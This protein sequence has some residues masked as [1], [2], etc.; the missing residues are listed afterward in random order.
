MSGFNIGE[1]LSKAKDKAKKKIVSKIKKSITPNKKG[2]NASPVKVIRDSVS[3]GLGNLASGGG[4]ILSNMGKQIFKTESNGKSVI[5]PAAGTCGGAKRQTVEEKF[6]D[7]IHDYQGKPKVFCSATEAAKLSLGIIKQDDVEG[8]ISENVLNDYLNVQYNIVFSMIPE[9]KTIKIQDAIPRDIDQPQRELIVDLRKSQAVILASTGGK[10]TNESVAIDVNARNEREGRRNNI[11]NGIA[12]PGSGQP[13]P[14]GIT[15]SAA[16][17]TAKLN[18]LRSAPYEPQFESVSVEDINYYAIQELVI[19]NSIAPTNSN[20]SISAMISAKM[21]LAEPGGFR[22]NDDIKVL[23]AMLGYENVNNGR[24]MYRLDISFSG[25]D[26]STGR[27]VETINMD[28]RKSKSKRIPFLTYYVT[29]T[30]MEATVTNTGTIY[31]INV[32]PVGAGAIRT[33]DFVVDAGAI[34]TGTPNTFGGFL[35]NFQ[36]N[37]QQKRSEETTQG[38]TRQTGITREYEI[39]APEPLRQSKFYS[40]AWAVEKGYLNE[41]PGGSIISSGKDIDILTVINAA[42]SDL[43]Y[44]HELF[45]AK[46]S[47]SDNSQFVRP[48][49]HFTVRFNVIYGVPNAEIA[50]YSNMKIQIIIEPFVSYKKGSYTAKTVGIYTALEAQTRRLTQM[51]SLGAIIRKYDYYNA[52]ANTEVLD[53]GINLS[54]FY[55]ESVDSSQDF[56]GTKGTGTASSGS[57]QV[58]NL[59]KS[60]SQAYAEAVQTQIGTSLTGIADNDDRFEVQKND[61]SVVS[62]TAASNGL[63]PY[64]ILGGGKSIFPDQYSY[65]SNTSEGAILAVRKNRYMREFKDWLANDQQQIDNL[66]VR[67]DPLWLLS[68]YASSDMNRLVQISEMIKP[69]TDSIIFI[70]IKAPNQRDYANPAN[71]DGSE[72]K[73]NPNVMG[74]FYGVYHVS[75]S[76]SGGSFTQTIQ[77]YKL[78]HL[79]YVEESISF[80]DII[81]S[82]IVSK[83]G[84]SGAAPGG[85][86]SPDAGKKAPA[87]IPVSETADILTI[88]IDRGAKDVAKATEVFK[89]RGTGND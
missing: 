55:T 33:E 12:P 1:T 77:G 21:V 78:N 8:G 72:R 57:Q 81:G 5:G 49:T 50:D 66:H 83:S 47:E 45:I 60:N 61:G 82:S 38:V 87:V 9:G 53:F 11:I 80:E 10:F 20:P 16:D 51:E 34:F 13:L 7:G 28:T 59:Q 62:K 2:K 35:D 56:P 24:M 52:S 15:G 23:G 85:Q 69:Q 54:S 89:V 86:I 63:T 26:P 25:Y 31:E 27:W 4:E 71:Y 36:S 3:S 17:I 70:N 22:L 43:P 29:I 39:I 67:G 46:T 76:F 19:D 32:A 73:A 79:N 74:G 68:P 42:L 58:E 48:R 37:L 6:K 64:G 84:V 40:Q 30:K 88:L 14:P 18:E 44:V 75:S 41:G 65:G